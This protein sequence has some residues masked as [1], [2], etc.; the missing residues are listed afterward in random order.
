L[1]AKLPYARFVAGQPEPDGL[2]RLAYY[3]NYA[4]WQKPSGLIDV[5]FFTHLD[6]SNRCLERA[7]AM[8][9]CVCQCRQYADWLLKQG[10]KSVTYIPMGYDAYR[11]RPRLVLGVV[12]L[13]NH[14]RKGWHL[15]E[16]VRKLPFVEVRTTDGGLSEEDLPAF[17]QGLDYVLIPATV[18]GGPMSLLEGLAMGKPIIAPEGVGMVPEFGDTRHI[19]RYPAGDAEALVQLVSQCYDEKQDRARLVKLRSWD[20]WAQSHH[21]LFMDLLTLGG[22]PEPEPAIG[23]RFGMMGELDVP[24]GIDVQRLE[25][26]IDSLARHLFW[27]QYAEARAQLQELVKTFSCAKPLLKTTPD[28]NGSF[29]RKNPY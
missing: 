13:L 3:I 5:G 26:G 4:L 1:G 20:A 6:E 27:G 14:P 24:F 7:R 28:E 16:A 8:Q 25:N 10:A 15:V 12:G 18:E 23:F 17:Y 11:Y 29:P 21:H 2:V 9:Y 22:Q 19:R